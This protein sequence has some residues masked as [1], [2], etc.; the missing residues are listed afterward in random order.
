M[1]SSFEPYSSSASQSAPIF[2]DRR[3]LEPYLSS[4]TPGVKF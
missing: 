1:K 3:S 2:L 4:K